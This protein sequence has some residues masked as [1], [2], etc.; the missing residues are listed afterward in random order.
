MTVLNGKILESVYL[1]LVQPLLV[2]HE[3]C[4]ILFDALDDEYLKS[5]G[6]FDL[7]CFFLGTYGPEL[8]IPSWVAVN[9]A[10]V[11]LYSEARTTNFLRDDQRN[12]RFRLLGSATS[13]PILPSQTPVRRRMQTLVTLAAVVCFCKPHSLITAKLQRLDLIARWQKRQAAPETN[14]GIAPFGIHA[15]SENTRLADTNIPALIAGQS[16]TYQLKAGFIYAQLE[17]VSSDQI[18]LR[19]QVK[20]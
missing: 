12:A 20:L 18:V 1:Q 17:A 4:L 14:P 15:F 9:K 6:A 8:L 16:T 2:G 11:R 7:N 19:T 3:T 13:R 10:T 5:V